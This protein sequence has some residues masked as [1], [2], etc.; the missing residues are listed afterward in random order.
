MKFDTSKLDPKY[1]SKRKHPTEDLWI[2]NYTKQAQFDWY[3]DK[4]TIVCRGLIVDG[5][6]N[7][8]SRPFKKFFTPEQYEDLD[9][10]DIEIPG[11]I[12][13]LY[14]VKYKNM[15]KGPFT[16]TEKMDGSLG[17][18]YFTS[19]GEMRI[20]TRGSFESP[21][22][23]LANRLLEKGPLFLDLKLK[24]TYLFEIC[25][26]DNKIVVNYDKDELVLLTIIDT[27]TGRELSREEINNENLPFQQTTKWV[28]FHSFEEVIQD[29][30]TQDKEGFNNREGYVVSFENGMRVKIKF[31]EYLRLH[32]IMTN[33]SE[34]RIWEV[35]VNREVYDLDNLMFLYNN[36][37]D[38][39]SKWVASTVDR[40]YKIYDTI[41]QQCL[42][43][44]LACLKLNSRKEQAELIKNRPHS[45]I[46]FAM[47]DG[48]YR[49]LS[50]QKK[51]WD[52]VWTIFEDKHKKDSL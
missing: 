36:T 46:V 21:Q 14:G 30:L 44:E 9:C 52:Y 13:K 29:K 18:S 15:Y 39:F 27:E 42:L 5:D 37:P 48:K 25:S 49:S 32:R 22:A 7:I 10:S 34:K 6:D 33:T 26:P 11:L 16:C 38:E 23:K 45:R 51:M 3:W 8:V 19:D 24:Y 50:L 40:L 43:D 20:A 1:I 28:V 31:D 41:Q 35:V 12:N 17:I 47:L 2:L 4:D